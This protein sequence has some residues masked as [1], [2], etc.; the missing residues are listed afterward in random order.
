M[1][2]LKTGSDAALCPA[3]AGPQAMRVRNPVLPHGSRRR[4]RLRVEGAVR[5]QEC[6]ETEGYLSWLEK[7]ELGMSSGIQQ[8]RLY[9]VSS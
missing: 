9:Q 3:Q 6:T 4:G 7:G 2:A 1:L 5:G 8:G